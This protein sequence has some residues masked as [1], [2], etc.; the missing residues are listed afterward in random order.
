M[1]TQLSSPSAKAGTGA[2]LDF[3]NRYVILQALVIIGTIIWIYWPSLHGGW[4]GD[5]SWYLTNN[6][7]L[8][9]PWRLWKAWFE[10]GSWVEFYPIEESIQWFQWLLWHDNTFGY[11]VTNVVLHIVSS[12]LLWHLFTKFGLRFAWLGAVLFAIHPEAVD[13]V[14]E[15]VELKNSLSLP[16]FI[17]A[18]CLYMDYEETKSRRCYLWA[19]VLF[20]V[21]MLC[22]ITMMSFPLII[23]LYAWWKRGRISWDD[24]KA[25]APFFLI[26]L[27]LG[28]TGLW[29][30]QVY[31]HPIKNWDPGEAILPGGLYRV[32]LAGQIVAFYFS[33]FF[34]P[35]D[36]MPIY[37]QW[38]VNP[39]HWASFLPWLIL[40][41]VTAYLWSPRHGWGRHALLGLGFFVLSLL[42]F[43]GTHSISFMNFTWIL[44][45][46]LYIPMIGLIG[47]VV[48]ALGQ[49]SGLLPGS[50]RPW[51]VAF[52]LLVLVL[53]AIQSRSYSAKFINEET[54]DRYNLQFVDNSMLRNNLGSALLVRS[55]YPEAFQQFQ[56]GLRCE[57][58]SSK[59]DFNLGS[60]YWKTGRINE[61]IRAYQ[62]SAVYAPDVGGTHGAMADTLFQAGRVPEAIE[63]YRQAIRLKFEMARMYGRLGE[64]LFLEGKKAEALQQFQHAVDL[65]PRSPLAQ[66][67]LA[68]ALCNTGQVGEGIKHYRVAIALEPDYAQA[69]NNL[70]I[71]L[72]HQGHADQALEEF[73]R[74]VEAEP[75]F[76]DARNNLA[77]A[78]RS[79]APAH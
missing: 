66:Y 58:H 47:L 3:L 36:P 31:A 52:L 19:V 15:I 73:H 2:T 23:L 44:D 56:L 20:L 10:P 77:L 14:A 67:N 71:A 37:P 30:G 6:P 8:R 9:D 5:D 54:L 25:S 76:A 69:H 24:I 7:L 62:Q 4:I 55:A 49:I 75:D 12:F 51:S 39:S 68:K 26:S 70:G 45:H 53:M 40:I 35:V 42:P 64:G 61:A 33:R 28:M 1:K 50:T 11:H 22:K 48:A 65:A 78:E 29:A 18:M 59:I 46:V 74:A 38:A 21:A 43:V 72:F 63:Q 32:A 79:Q 16:P 17:L 60:L 27:A 34:L 41:P 13:S 57:P